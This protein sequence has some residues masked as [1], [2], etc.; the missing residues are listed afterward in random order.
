MVQ[1]GSRQTNELELSLGPCPTPMLVR[2]R[3]HHPPFAC[4][5]ACLRVSPCLLAPE[6]QVV[7]PCNLGYQLQLPAGA[8]PRENTDTCLQVS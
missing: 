5:L 6:A 2:M 7:P 3:P 4:L 1:E 8:C